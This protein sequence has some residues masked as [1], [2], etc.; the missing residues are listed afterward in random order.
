MAKSARTAAEREARAV[1]AADLYMHGK[2]E[3]AA[4]LGHDEA[5]RM[6][7]RLDMPTVQR[8]VNHL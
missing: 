6:M 8:E 2:I 4:E 1:A 3:D 7:R 5:I